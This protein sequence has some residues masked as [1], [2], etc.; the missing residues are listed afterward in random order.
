MG[1][2]I[3]FLCTLCLGLVSCVKDDMNVVQGDGMT[4][5]RAVYSEMPQSRTVLSG[6]TP[7]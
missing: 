4:V 5:F 7:Y 2:H 1:K 3:L 6:M